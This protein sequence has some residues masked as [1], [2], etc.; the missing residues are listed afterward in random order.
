MATKSATVHGS[1]GVDGHGQRCLGLFDDLLRRR[2]RNVGGSWP[3]D[4]DRL[5]PLEHG[6]D[7]LPRG[8]LD[9]GPAL[10]AQGQS[11]LAMM[12]VHKLAVAWEASA[13][14]SR[15]LTNL[16]GNNFYAHEIDSLLD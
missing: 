5:R 8:V 3:G 14:A 2:P 10:W 6:H 9:R 7:Q 16:V 4:F 11:C 13:V 1:D 12:E 15:E